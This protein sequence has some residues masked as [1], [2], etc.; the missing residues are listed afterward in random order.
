MTVNVTYPKISGMINGYEYNKESYTGDTVSGICTYSITNS[1]YTLSVSL[2]GFTGDTVTNKQT[3]PTINNS[4]NVAYLSEEELGCLNEGN[5]IIKIMSTGATY[6]Y[7][8]EKIGPV[9]YKS[10][11]G[12]ISNDKYC[13]VDEKGNMSVT[14]PQKDKEIEI[15]GKYKYFLG[16]LSNDDVNSISS[17]TTDITTIIRKESN[18]IKEGW[19]NINTDT[20]IL[21]ETNEDVKNNDGKSIYLACPQKY[22]LKTFTNENGNSLMGNFGNIPIEADIKTGSIISKYDIYVYKITSGVDIAFKGVKIGLN[23]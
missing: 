1:A 7:T 6:S 23:N 14:A 20:I 5:N 4:N 3:S 17:T 8:S 19:V 2:T 11:I 9:Y 15:T 16:C 13:E 18:I 21:G 10:N 22:K 12:N